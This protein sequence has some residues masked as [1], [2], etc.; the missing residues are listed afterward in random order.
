MKKIAIITALFT[1]FTI[2]AKAQTTVSATATQTVNLNLTDVI[3]ISF[4]GSG[5]STGGVVNLPFNTVTDY[6]NGVTSTDQQ[7]VV[8]STRHFNVSV[9]S[10][11]VNFTYTGTTSPAPSVQISNVLQMMVTANGTGGSLS[12]ST[13]APIS[14]G[15]GTIINY[16]SPGG[17]Q[18]FSVKYKANPGFSLPGGTYTANIVYTATQQ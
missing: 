4:V 12:Y 9:Q 5:S 13:Y 8:M 10:N 1:A 17:N 2:T 6:A 14:S 18:T 16:G 3:Y 7:M 15:A 11:A